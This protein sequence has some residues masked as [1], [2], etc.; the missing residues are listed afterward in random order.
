M[1][2]LRRTAPHSPRSSRYDVDHVSRFSGR[3]LSLQILHRQSSL[4]Y[5]GIFEH[6]TE[7]FPEDT[8]REK[9]ERE[10]GRTTS[11]RPTR[12]EQGRR[13][14]ILNPSIMDSIASAIEALAQRICCHPF[15]LPSSDSC[16]RRCVDKGTRSSC[17]HEDPNFPRE[18]FILNTAS[19]TPKVPSVIVEPPAITRLANSRLLFGDERRTPNEVRCEDRGCVHHGHAAAERQHFLF[20]L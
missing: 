17:L 9:K 7:A 8:E 4:I 20:D 11:H 1:E 10:L 14:R 12:H 19:K 6:C 2:R 5:L 16:T 18:V 3:L 15:A 13:N